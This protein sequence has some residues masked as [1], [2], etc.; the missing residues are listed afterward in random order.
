MKK[1]FQKI[2]AFVKFLFGGDLDKW[3]DK[4]VQPSIEFVQRLKA[5]VDSPVAN[6]VTALIPGTWDDKLKDFWSNNLAKAI[7][8]LYITQDIASEPDW[9]NKIIKLIGY[10]KSCSPA[11]RSAIYKQLSV[12]MAKLSNESYNSNGNKPRTHAIDLLVQMQYSKLRSGV[13]ADDLSDED[14]ETLSVAA[15]TTAATAPPSK[16][17]PVTKAAKKKATK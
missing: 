17:P 6:L 11:M 8:L 7:D 4:H 1:F 15:A 14:N 10:L 16:K 13:E 12:E 3:T 2:V 5:A 9:T